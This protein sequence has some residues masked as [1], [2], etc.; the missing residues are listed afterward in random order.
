MINLFL[1]GFSKEKKKGEGEDRACE[2]ERKIRKHASLRRATC[3]S[4]RPAGA[5]APRLS[6]EKKAGFFFSSRFR[7]DIGRTLIKPRLS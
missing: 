5:A 2:R 1:G 3:K 4:P 7:V 6:R